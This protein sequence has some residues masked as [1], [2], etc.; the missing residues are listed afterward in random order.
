[1][2]T[3]A[4]LPAEPISPE[5]IHSC[6]SCSHW[7]PE[8][9]LACPD[10]QT[11]TY[12]QHLSDVAHS[13]QN[14]EQEGKWPEARDRWR[15]ALGWLPE[16]TPQFEAIQGHIGQIDA[17]LNAEVERKAKWTKRLGPFAPLFF[18]LLKLKSA[19]FFLFK[20][21][22]FLGLFAFFG[23]YW[24]LAGWKFALGFTISIFLHEMGHFVAVK[25]RGLKADPPMFIP[26]MG[27]YVRWYHQG[28]SLEDLASISLAGPLYGLGTAVLCLLIGFALPPRSQGHMLFLLLANIGAWYNLF[29]LTPVLGFD[30]AQATYALSRVQRILLTL[31]CLLFFGLT[32]ADGNPN[33]AG[34]QWVFLIVAAGM[35]W[36]SFTSD[37]PETPHTKT[38]T[39]FLALILG[40]GFLLFLTPVPGMQ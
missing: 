37:A 30:G 14:L 21:K 26:G 3:S 10:C 32:V 9:T 36:R 13:A 25:R 7:L 23:L 16:N 18:F 8:G 22:F 35:G 27:A 17:R 40:L 29:N 6:P 39:M 38:L 31:T 11:L 1:M 19:L 5:P 34:T 24:A 2:S 15:S 4:V 28:V 12:G 20:L 33:R